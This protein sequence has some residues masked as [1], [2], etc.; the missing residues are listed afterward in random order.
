MSAAETPIPSGEVPAATDEDGPPSE[1][2]NLLVLALQQILV[3]IGWIFKTESVIMPAFVDTIAGPG[4]VRGFLPILNRIGQSIPPLLFAETLR[5]TPLKR[6]SLGLAAVG[7]GVPFLIL[8]G[9]LQIPNAVGSIWFP[10]VFLMLY[11][12]FFSMTG[13][14][15]LVFGTLTGKLI[16]PNR[17]GRLMAISGIVGVILAITSAWNLLPGWLEQGPVGFS[18]IFVF[19]GVFFVVAGGASLFLDERPDNFERGRKVAPFRDAVRRVRS[20]RHLARL[21]IVAMLFVSAL[22]LVP[23]YQ[24]L[25]LGSRRRP[26]LSILMVWVVAQ[27]ATAGALSLLSGFIAD[28]YGYRLAIRILLFLSACCP[29]LA[30]AVSVWA[31]PKW[32]ILS[33][34]LFGAVPNTFRVLQNYSLEI[35][36]TDNHAQYI[37]TLKLFMP[38]ALL[39]SPV[40]GLLIDAI[41]FAPVFIAIGMVNMVGVV[42]T[43]FMEEPRHWPTT[44]HT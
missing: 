23:H 4:W 15:Q 1:S 29:L 9:L 10:V 35:T 13:V 44:N 33:F 7:M 8:A 24:A 39:L 43:F 40:F 37:S 6:G 41:G 34:M 16:A 19:V 12:F 28:R 14:N 36:T 2:R 18:R 3:R 31:D 32:F 42:M 38:L 20:D 11:L 21:L 26:D 30:I 27:N 5:S 17:R 25:A 22:L